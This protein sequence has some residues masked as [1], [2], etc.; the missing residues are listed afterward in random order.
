MLHWPF[1]TGPGLSPAVGVRTSTHHTQLFGASLQPSQ[2]LHFAAASDKT[3]LIGYLPSWIL[4]WMQI[5]NLYV[6]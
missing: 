6:S 3:Q 4:F 1:L 2:T 5:I